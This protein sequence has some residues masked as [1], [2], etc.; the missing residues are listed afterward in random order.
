MNQQQP[1]TGFVFNHKWTKQTFNLCLAHNPWQYA[2]RTQERYSVW[3]KIS[4][5]LM[6][7][8]IH[9]GRRSKHYDLVYYRV[10]AFVKLRLF[11]A[12]FFFFE[13]I[14]C[15]MRL[16]GIYY[17]RLSQYEELRYFNIF[18]NGIP[19]EPDGMSY[20]EDMT[21]LERFVLNIV[22]VTMCAHLT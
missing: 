21:E 9:A 12:F 6:I 22:I 7:M 8:R 13:Y 2:P 11:G 16:I 1:T 20:E 14:F 17:K 15:V 3:H 18:A 19:D 5:R 10:A 4:E